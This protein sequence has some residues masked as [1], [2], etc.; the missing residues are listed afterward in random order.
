MLSAVHSVQM[1]LHIGTTLCLETQHWED[2]KD[3]ALISRGLAV[4]A[5]STYIPVLK[6]ERVKWSTVSTVAASK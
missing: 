4:S 6:Q 5:G 3:D 1:H 2:T